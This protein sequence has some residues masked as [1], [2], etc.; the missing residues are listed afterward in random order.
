MPRII[1][2]DGRRL[3]FSDWGDPGGRPVIVCPGAGMAGALPF[4]DDAARAAGLR[5]VSLDRPGLGGSDPLPGRTLDDWAQDV[6]ALLADL[7][8][9]SAPA[10]GFS[11]GAVFALA[12]AAAGLAPRVALVSG[13]DELAD[14]AVLAQLPG[15]VADVVRRAATDPAALE[16]EIATTA[17]AEWLWQMIEDMSGPADRAFHAAPDF[18]PR[19]RAALAAG[20]AQGAAGYARDTVLALAPWPFRVED[21][22]GPVHLWYGLSDTSPVHS[23]DFGATLA[24]RL[25]RPARHTVAGE[26][27]A[28]LWTRAAAILAALDG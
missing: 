4:G 27:S 19:Y 11:Q 14:P 7:G 24:A 21:I 12:L 17:T 13:Q 9:A 5:L 8:V 15:P 2:G 6:A 16:T 23:P 22:A 18:A 3:A 28:I 20:F 1:L 25:A 10:I 26:G